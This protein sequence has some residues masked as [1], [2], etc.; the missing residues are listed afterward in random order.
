M[1]STIKSTSRPMVRP[2][3]VRSARAS[4]G[5]KMTG[6]RWSHPAARPPLNAPRVVAI[7]WDRHFE[8][9]Q[10]D[11]QAFDELLRTLFRSSW[12][13]GLNEAGVPPAELLGSFV[14]SDPAPASL[15]R[16]ELEGRLIEWLEDGRVTP[17]PRQAD[18]SLV[19]LIVTPLGTELR[20]DAHSWQMR[21]AGH[22]GCTHYG[23][24]ASRGT[25][26]PN[27]VY[28]AVP[29]VSTGPE[30]L[31][32]HSLAITQELGRALIARSRVV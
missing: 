28:V 9:A 21:F 4:K 10:A 3:P 22:C 29:L 23:A 15:T 26:R 25:A 1:P 24:D 30:I 27:V 18:G 8:G 19:Y 12:M 16:V 11:V 17:K 14:L 32:L 20:E 6:P 7:Y 31:D 13:S 2:S 5:R